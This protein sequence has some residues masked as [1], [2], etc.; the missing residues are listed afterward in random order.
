ML[1]A[2]TS[3]DLP[4]PC[5]RVT[6]LLVLQGIEEATMAYNLYPVSIDLWLT[7]HIILD[8]VSRYCT[9]SLL[10]QARLCQT[11]C[12]PPAAS[13]N[14]ADHAEAAGNDALISAATVRPG[15]D[16]CQGWSRG[17]GLAAG[18]TATQ[19]ASYPGHAGTGCT[20]A[21]GWGGT[22]PHAA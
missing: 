10:L 18:P 15:A 14:L 11:G 17:T 20:P 1:G 16:A 7:A 22:G 12:A 3:R 9:V 2:C 4:G 19:P 6:V 8:Q 13:E 21:A 5:P